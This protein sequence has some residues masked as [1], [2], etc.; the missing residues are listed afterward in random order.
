MKRKLITTCALVLFSFVFVP[1]FAF[2]YDGAT[3]HPALTNEIVDFY[4]LTHPESK[5]TDEERGW[6]IEGS[7]NEDTP[8][9]WLNHFY[10]PIHKVGWNG[11]K[12]GTL[13]A[14]V[15]Q[16]IARFGLS[17]KKPLSAVEWVNGDIQQ[18]DYSR[19]GG[20]ETW[21]KAL[22]AYV[23][24][25]KRTAFIALGHTL[26]LLED[27]AV[28]DHTRNDTHAP[29]IGVD[30]SSPYESYATQFDM[31]GIKR[32]YIAKNLAFLKVSEIQKS[33][34]DES[35]TSLAEYSN[36]HF[37]S[38]DTINDIRFEFPKIVEVKD[39]FGYGIDER[40][41]KF[42][43]V[44]AD[45]KSEKE[46]GVGITYSLKDRK[47]YWPIFNAY[48]LRLSKQV[49]LRGA[50]VIDLFN[51]SIENARIAKEFQPRILKFDFSVFRAP[52]LS[53]YG[54]LA[55]LGNSARTGFMNVKD[56]V[57]SA[58]GFFGGSGTSTDVPKNSEVSFN[59][60]AQNIVEIPTSYPD[61]TF[62]YSDTVKNQ[63]TSQEVV[64]ETL[65]NVAEQIVPSSTE[66]IVKE[67]QASS[68]PV[69]ET[70]TT[71]ARTIV[72]RYYG[73][74]G[75][76]DSTPTKTLGCVGGN[77]KITEIMYD[78]SG[79]DSEREWIELY[80][81]GTGP[82]VMTDAKF[83]EG[84][85]NHLINAVRGGNDLAPGGYAILASNGD[86]FIAENTAYSGP[87]F[88]SAFSLSNDNE[89]LA[90]KCGEGVLDIATY[91]SST[92]AHGDGSSLQIFDGIWRASMPTMGRANVY[93][94][95]IDPRG[96]K[97]NFSYEPASPH[98][99]D[100]VQFDA[101]SSTD[102]RGE[103]IEYSWDMGDGAFIS[104]S[105]AKISHVFSRADNITV[106]LTIRD[107]GGN[108]SSTSKQLTLLPTT[109]ANTQNP[110]ISEVQVG[111]ARAD[112]EFI[113]LYNPT[114]APISLSGYSM[115]YLS[116]KATSTDSIKNGSAKE[117]FPDNA[118]IQPYSFY[119][120]VESG[121]IS[122]L[123]DR[124]DM[125]YTHFSLSGD[126][127]GAV[128]FLV[129]KTSYISD[130][131]DNTI[132]DSLA[133]GNVMLPNMSSAPMPS[134]GGS[135]ERKA[136][137]TSSAES[138][139]SGSDRFIGNGYSSHNSSFDFVTQRV[140]NAQGS[141]NYPES[142][143]QP[144]APLGTDGTAD[145][146]GSY[147]VASTSI[148]F[149]WLPSED[150]S[151]STST[152]SYKIYMVDEASSSLI[153]ETT[154]TSYLFPM[155]FATHTYLFDLY[156][157]DKDGL[158]SPAT[159][160]SVLV[161]KNKIPV[162]SFLPNAPNP[163]LNDVVTFDGTASTDSDGSIASY[164]WQ[165][166]DGI[167]LEVAT[168]V[169]ASHAFSIVGTHNITLIATDNEGA[170]ASSTTSLVVAP[171]LE[172]TD[173][174]Y[175]LSQEDFS[176]GGV[177]NAGYQSSM[178]FQYLGTGLKDII[179]S[180]SVYMTQNNYSGAPASLSA[181]LYESDALNEKPR[182]R[183]LDLY[184]PRGVDGDWITFGIAFT[185]NPEK[186]YWLAVPAHAAGFLSQ[187]PAKSSVLAYYPYDARYI[188][189]Y[190]DSFL[191]G[192]LYRDN[193]TENSSL[194][195]RVNGTLP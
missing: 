128:V 33:T 49:V 178:Q 43:L 16:T 125:E 42:L 113:E 110:V 80:N 74:G 115:Q 37:F 131:A 55:N 150:F 4:N 139:Y 64:A 172:I 53:L 184:N 65:P 158:C 127:S 66:L 27:M 187:V 107:N 24:E 93:T 86:T 154:S 34:I 143:V 45:I 23:S 70:S 185:P 145:T 12:E 35:L 179:T 181:Q 168:S 72:T 62:T 77:I 32:L 90:F 89:A 94:A 180:I 15:V 95:P 190:F 183:V 126:E 157:C 116:G 8:P 103:I 25:D 117:N 22:D 177:A 151:G 133:Y 51:G 134:V 20:N 106:T 29:I 57:V 111:G 19:Y 36:K 120:L 21:K 78:L 108:T 130:V 156:A 160:F 97:P 132:V 54:E 135:L 114:G 75:G 92:G 2:A 56:F 162:V 188:Y 118:V 175:L 153:G 68:T 105:S 63:A 109:S 69:R 71:T 186:H 14:G 84:G 191:G 76:G 11:E 44:G 5:L 161:R 30:D 146:I 85:T 193:P 123:K 13:P 61:E 1:H 140:A 173:R 60:T 50:G 166:D 6:L 46:K 164:E 152:L 26:H 9:R 121:A 102:E 122:S 31:K 58:G 7:K 171:K 192:G 119:L 100:V 81:A 148:V 73:G 39:G 104:S 67:V 48:F 41:S 59:T 124:A 28:P 96:P 165:F 189:G 182:I 18:T 129:N 112:D 176:G 87:V 10:D 147:D 99:G 98:V 88:H 79:T 91:A 170:I 149:R 138:L 144:K 136:T 195:Y 194:A 83:V 141:K 47:E 38:K 174:A 3:T 101:A 155:D 169:I 17:Q 142:R 163:R 167:P 159:E 52:V 40:G 82:V 137:A